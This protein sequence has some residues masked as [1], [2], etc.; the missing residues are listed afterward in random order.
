MLCEVCGMRIG[1]GSLSRWLDDSLV[2][3]E[4]F[5]EAFMEAWLER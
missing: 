2:C 4:C 3:E 5:N 1:S